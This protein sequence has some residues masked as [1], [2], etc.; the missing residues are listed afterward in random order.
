MSSGRRWASGMRQS[1]GI[2]YGTDGAGL[3][4]MF[5]RGAQCACRVAEVV[6]H[7]PRRLEWI[8]IW[9]GECAVGG[10][11]VRAPQHD[12][13]GPELGSVDRGQGVWVCP[14]AAADQRPSSPRHLTQQRFN[15]WFDLA[16]HW[17]SLVMSAGGRVLINRP[18]WLPRRS[19]A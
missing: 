11:A 5:N 13:V 9:S 12:H 14:G 2:G 4:G 3:G 17:Q 15:V 7:D 1:W 18:L 8:I 19:A 10:G 6:P 16:A